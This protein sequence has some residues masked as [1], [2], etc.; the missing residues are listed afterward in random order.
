MA[1]DE[2][3][4]SNESNEDYEVVPLG[5]IRKLEKRLDQIE[6]QSHQ[7]GPGD[8]FVRDVLDIMKSNQKIVNDM[9][10][11]THELQNSVEDL[12]HKMDDVI[13][14]MNEFMELL[15]EAS[16]MDMEGEVV[17]DLRNRI[18]EAVGDRLEDVVGDMQESNQ[19]I[20]EGLND[21][22]ESIRRSYAA[23]NKEGILAGG[24]EG[25][26]RQ[27]Q[28]QGRGRQRGQGQERQ[29]QGQGLT[30]R[31]GNEQGQG[32]SNRMRKL[33]KRFDKMDDEQ[34]E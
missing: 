10:E 25:G 16:E 32:S 9:T 30:D 4:L 33:R 6:A 31:A 19:E 20:V 26:Q 34:E 11:S 8:D 3:D 12:T 2:V 5:P 23:G 22:N 27:Q 29:Q 17:G 28:R 15:S 7:S 13:D 21:L 24:G 1:D 18:A 14:N